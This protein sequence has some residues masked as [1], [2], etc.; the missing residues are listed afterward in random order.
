METYIIVRKI[1]NTIM[2]VG[3]VGYRSFDE[4]QKEANAINAKENEN[5]KAYIHTVIVN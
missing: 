3:E 4:A 1:Y 5:I 2:K